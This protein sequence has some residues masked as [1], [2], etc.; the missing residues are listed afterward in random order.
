MR[1]I[2]EIGH[3]AHVHHFKQMYWKLVQMGHNGLFVTKNKECELDLLLT[4][5]FLLAFLGK[6]PKE[7]FNK[8]TYFL[9]RDLKMLQ[10]SRIF[11]PNIFISSVAQDYAIT[12]RLVRIS[13]LHFANTVSIKCSD[14]MRFNVL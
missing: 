5:Q 7:M 12:R 8:L 10:T 13:N 1:F 14:W 11:K 3:P 6:T 9:I 2:V 4:F